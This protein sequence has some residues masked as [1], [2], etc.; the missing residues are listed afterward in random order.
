MLQSYDYPTQE[1]PFQ[2]SPRYL[3]KQVTIEWLSQVKKQSKRIFMQWSG[4]YISS[5]EMPIAIWM[6]AVC[7]NLI[8]FKKTLLEKT[9]VRLEIRKRELAL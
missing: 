9:V 7:L 6:G 8:P 4:D 3:F 5:G 1:L 2:F